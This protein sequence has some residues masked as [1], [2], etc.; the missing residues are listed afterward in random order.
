MTARGAGDDTDALYGIPPAEFIRARNA[1][2]GKLR[3]AGRR[4]DAAAVARLR[5]PTP[6]VWAVNQVAREARDAVTALLQ[7]AE[8]LK[9]RRLIQAQDA[10]AALDAQRAALDRVAAHA[11]QRLRTIG[12]RP[13][14]AIERRMSGTL[15]GALSDAGAREAFRAGRLT[16]ELEAPGFQVLGGAVARLVASTPRQAREHTEDQRE[17]ERAA[18]RE[19]RAELRR[20]ADELDREAAAH[21][22]RAREAMAAAADFRR[23][24]KEM[25]TEAATAAAAARKARRAA[26]RARTR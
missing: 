10:R 1:L 5:K 23:R 7:A 16:M 14:P 22:Q 2:A 26:A 15:L 6:V 25:A 18:V 24:A 4:S 21:E 9:G 19:R 12:I 3:E 8:G 13:T 11:R 17:A 20:Q